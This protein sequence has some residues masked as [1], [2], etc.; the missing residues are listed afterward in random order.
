MEYLMLL[1]GLG[2]RAV[3]HA[4]DAKTALAAVEKCLPRVILL[5]IKLRG[6]TDGIEV[7]E[8]IRRRHDVPI[9]FITSYADADTLGRAWRT[10]PAYVLNKIGD[11][12][13]LCRVVVELMAA[14]GTISGN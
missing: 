12:R 3:E 9:V 14:Q 2:Y 8:V 7:A 6:S 5:D 10:R 13:E 4:F 1:R 11:H